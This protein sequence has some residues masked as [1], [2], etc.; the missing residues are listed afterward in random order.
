[1]SRMRFNPSQIAFL[2]NAMLQVQKSQETTAVLVDNIAFT[3][4]SNKLQVYTVY[5]VFF[6]LMSLG[7]LSAC[8]LSLYIP[9]GYSFTLLLHIF[10]MSV[11]VQSFAVGLLTSS[12]L[13]QQYFAAVCLFLSPFTPQQ[14]K[15][16][17]FCMIYLMVISLY[18]L[19]NVSNQRIFKWMSLL[20]ILLKVIS[21][22]LF[23][24]VY[25]LFWW[26]TQ[27]VLLIY[28]L[29]LLLWFYCNKKYC[30]TVTA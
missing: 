12:S 2:Q 11:F 29:G 21:N 19:S 8:V 1:M 26:H 24:T 25:S 22:C 10:T 5:P 30:I 3:P 27:I 16:E 20:G 13:A 23:L 6:W 7:S 17:S 15:N 28:D 14:L 9:I 18:V 4:P